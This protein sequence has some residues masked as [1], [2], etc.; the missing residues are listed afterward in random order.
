ME[1]QQMLKLL[2][3]ANQEKEEADRKAYHEALNEI[4]FNMKS[5][6]VDML[7]RMEE[8]MEANTKA[9]QEDMLT[10]MQEKMEANTKANQEDMLARMQ[11]DIKSGQA[12]M[13]SIF[14]AWLTDLKDG[15]KE[16]TAYQETTESEPNP[17]MMQSIEGHQKI[18]KGEAGGMQVGEPKKRRRVWNLAAERRQKP[19]ERT[20]GYCESRRKLAA[21]CRKVSSRAKVA[22]RRRNIIRKM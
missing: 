2:L 17:G 3:L 14:D 20:Q 12:E 7:T 6:Q 21:A 9:N 19:K 11:E 18:P 5:N 15:R 13:R 8:K 16:T 4:N 1:M 22:W 10:R